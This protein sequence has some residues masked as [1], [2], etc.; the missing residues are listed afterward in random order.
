LS[1]PV[2]LLYCTESFVCLRWFLS[3]SDRILTLVR[4]SLQTNK[5]KHKKSKFKFE[6][7]L[8]GLARLVRCFFCTL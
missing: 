3:G 7:K 5:Q 8:L 4:Y 6:C 2:S 1:Y